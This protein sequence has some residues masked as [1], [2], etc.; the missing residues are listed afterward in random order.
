MGQR[1][2]APNR[3]DWIDLTIDYHYCGDKRWNLD[4]EFWACSD[5]SITEVDC[6]RRRR[7]EAWP[8][9]SKTMQAMPTSFLSVFLR[10]GCHYEMIKSG[11]T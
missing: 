1:V 3:E 2:R 4:E 10:C 5:T 6:R 9:T 11:V 8:T 7:S